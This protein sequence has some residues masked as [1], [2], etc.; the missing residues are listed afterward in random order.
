MI[1]KGESVTVT[2]KESAEDL[3]FY[4][5]QLEYVFEPGEFEFF[6]AGS[7]DSEFDGSFTL[8]VN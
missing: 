7:S 3:K 1:K 4:N 5:S 2:F 6:I 8:K